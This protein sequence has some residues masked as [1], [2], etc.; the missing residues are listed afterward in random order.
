MEQNFLNLN[1]MLFITIYPLYLELP[2]LM[3]FIFIESNQFLICGS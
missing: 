3:C 2:F 1:L